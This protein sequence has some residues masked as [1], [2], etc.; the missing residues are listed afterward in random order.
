MPL[1]EAG[2][3]TRRPGEIGPRR[4][5]RDT[6]LAGAGWQRRFTGAPP[7]LVEVTELYEALGWEVMLDELSPEELPEDCG[8][9]SL[10]LSFFRVVYTRRRPEEGPERGDPS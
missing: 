6:E 10:A 1:R 4:E 3:G 2:L 9:C 8:G 5:A 7:R